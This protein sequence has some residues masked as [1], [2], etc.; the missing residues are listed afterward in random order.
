MPTGHRDVLVAM[1][2]AFS[3]HGP[4]DEGLWWSSDCRIGLGHRRL[5]I[6]DLSPAGHQ[7]MADDRGD[8]HVVFNGEIYN[9]LEFREE[10]RSRPFC[11]VRHSRIVRRAD[12]WTK[13]RQPPVHPHPV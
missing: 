12:S 9:F 7:P 4:D 6:I 5:S 3:H 2:D 13:Q 11:A 10:R 8:I 1:R